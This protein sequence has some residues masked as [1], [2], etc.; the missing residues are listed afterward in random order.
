MTQPGWITDPNMPTARAWAAGAHPQN[1]TPGSFL[2]L[3]GAPA[4]GVVELFDK[5]T[6]KWKSGNSMPTGRGH[7]AAAAWNSTVLAVGGSNGTGVLGAFEAYD[8]L[9]QSWSQ[10]APMPTP[11]E[12]LGAAVI[13]DLLI[14][15][16]GDDGASPPHPLDTVEIYSLKTKTWSR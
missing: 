7:L 4:Q 16:G 6:N 1:T 5:E 10:L 9:M 3:G 12:G 15:I 11:R 8:L 13:G 2:V 14:A